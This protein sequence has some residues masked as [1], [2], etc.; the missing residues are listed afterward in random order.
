M[1]ISFS[2]FGVSMSVSDGYAILFIIICN[3]I[4]IGLFFLL[5][6]IINQVIVI[7]KYFT[8]KNGHMNDDVWKYGIDA[9]IYPD[10][11]VEEYCRLRTEETG[12]RHD[13]HFV[14][15]RRHVMCLTERPT[16]FD[17]IERIRKK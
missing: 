3:L 9:G 4:L 13:W 11:N 7:I 1:T 8:Q 15:G 6:I 5:S 12:Y 17:R 2:L 16:L 10:E 14:G